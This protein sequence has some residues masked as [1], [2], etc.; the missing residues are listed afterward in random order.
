MSPELAMLLSPSTVNPEALDALYALGH[1][2]LFQSDAPRSA[3]PVFRVMLA[4][5]P[6][7]ERGWL[8]VGECHLRLDESDIALEI[9][10]AATVA[11]KRSA[12]CHVARAR[13]LRAEGR[14][15]DAEDALDEAVAIAEANDDDELFAIVVRERRAS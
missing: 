10:G 1:H 14:R 11:S 8:G 12:R 5:A 13:I 7:D 6:T 9:F 15:R 3:L 2:L 4:C